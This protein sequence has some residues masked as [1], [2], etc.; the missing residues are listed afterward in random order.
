MVMPLI[1]KVL[2]DPYT[3]RYYNATLQR[4]KEPPKSFPG[5][6]NTDLISDRAIGFLEEA[7]AGDAPFFIGVMPIG[8][9]TETVVPEHPGEND[10]P[11]FLPPVPAERH[12]DLYQ[13]VKIPRTDNFNPEKVSLTNLFDCE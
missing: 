4:N 5:E 10:L 1:C 3:Y 11:I 12:K 9:H 13:G 7:A 2:L 8:P 6:Y